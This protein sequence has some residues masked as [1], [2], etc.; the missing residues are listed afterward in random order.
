MVALQ[1]LKAVVVAVS[2]AVAV[3]LRLDAV[4]VEMI[5]DDFFIKKDHCLLA[6]SSIWILFFDQTHPLQPATPARS[7]AVAPGATS[8]Q[9]A[10][11]TT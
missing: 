3:G 4:T 5:P 1:D 8:G 7:P 9:P 10:P 6:Y 11:Q 2:M